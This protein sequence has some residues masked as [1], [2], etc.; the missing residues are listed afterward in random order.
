MIKI[1]IESLWRMFTVVVVLNFLGYIPMTFNEDIVIKLV[2]IVC[3]LYYMLI[4]AIEDI[5]KSKDKKIKEKK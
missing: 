2:L 1:Y 4:P 5:F 3:G